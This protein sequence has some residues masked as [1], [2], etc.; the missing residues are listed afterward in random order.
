MNAVQDL[1]KLQRCGA[2]IGS[3]VTFARKI[4]FLPTKKFY[5][6]KPQGFRMN[7][8]QDLDKL[9]RCGATIGSNVTFACKIIFLPPAEN[10]F[11]IC[12]GGVEL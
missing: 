6:R 9:Q 7:A 2:T 3:N 10:F 5:A 11:T 12:A 8:A 4:I 1:D